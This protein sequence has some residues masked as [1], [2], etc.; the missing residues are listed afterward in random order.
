MLADGR[1][2]GPPQLDAKSETGKY[3]LQVALDLG[4]ASV[5]AITGGERIGFTLPMHHD[6]R[7]LIGLRLGNVAAHYFIEHLWE[8]FVAQIFGVKD[9]PAKSFRSCL[10]VYNAEYGD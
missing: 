4:C 7:I 1:Q 2:S 6:H 10:F 9:N 3:C 8:E 5:P